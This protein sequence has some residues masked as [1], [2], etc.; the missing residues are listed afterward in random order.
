[1]F[2]SATDTNRDSDITMMATSNSK[3]RD[4]DDWKALLKTADS[5]FTLKEIRRT[6]G[7]KLDLIV[8]RW[9]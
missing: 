1:L 8:A 3:E 4:E 9:K 2:V 7:A 5:N 6:P